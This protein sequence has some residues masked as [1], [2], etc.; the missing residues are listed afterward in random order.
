M[1][2]LTR[3]NLLG[4]ALAAGAGATVLGA[5]A[6]AADASSKTSPFG[7]ISFEDPAFIAGRVVDS[8]AGILVAEDAD[9]KLR[10]IRMRDVSQVWK[11]GVWRIGGLSVGDCIYG[12]GTLEPDG[13]LAIDKA[14]VSIFNHYGAVRS[15]S[16]LGLAVDIADGEP[17]T[18]SASPPMRSLPKFAAGHGVQ[19]VGFQSATGELAATRL[20]PD[21]PESKPG[22]QELAAASQGFFGVASWQCCGGINACGSQDCSIGRCCPAPSSHG[23]CGTCRTDRAGTAWPHLTTGC[24]ASCISCCVTLPSVACG[25]VIQVIN[26]CTGLGANCPVND[27]GPNAR[28]VPTNRCFGYQVVK[29]DLTACS[30]TATGGNLDAGLFDGQAIIT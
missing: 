20:I 30:F 14:W 28:C 13:T 22:A 18:V 3:R 16:A 21:V 26:F 15:S 8:G 5:V 6:D 9:A 27:C 10:R 2:Q 17:L 4:K 12:R 24:S 11:E 23:A 1:D 25:H 7:Q 29:W 19:V